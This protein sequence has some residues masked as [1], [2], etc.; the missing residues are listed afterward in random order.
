MQR[1]QHKGL[2]KLLQ[3]W[4]KG[5]A[6][7]KEENQLSKLAEEDAFLADALQGYQSVPESD[8]SAKIEKL[9]EKLSPDQKKVAIFSLPLMRVAASIAIIVFAIATLWYLNREPQNKLA[10]V[11]ME[12]QE[13]AEKG[14]GT[15]KESIAEKVEPQMT[16][17]QIAEEAKA[18]SP[19]AVTAP[20][21]KASRGKK[22]LE[23]GS[24][25]KREKDLNTEKSDV[26]ESPLRE[27]EPSPPVDEIALDES[28]FE[29]EKAEPAPAVEEEAEMMA[30]EDAVVTVPQEAQR[31]EETVADDMIPEKP[32][33]IIGRVLDSN[34]EPLIGAN[35]VVP[36]SAKG[37]LTDIDGN[38]R[39]EVPEGFNEIEVSYT[40]YGNLRQNL[41]AFDTM[42]F[43][44]DEALELSEVVV[45]AYQ[46]EKKKAAT[47][48]SNSQVAGK[49]KAIS[50]PKPKGGFKKFD[51][52]LRKNMQ[53][54]AA[55]KNASIE[56]KVIVDFLLDTEGKPTVFTIVQA[57][58]YGCDEEAIRLL[59]EGPKWYARQGQKVNYTIYFK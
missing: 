48:K 44:L 5:E 32:R 49:A 35:I 52:Y 55:A 50:P 57:L 16:Q 18:E 6:T 53:Y 4:L 28:A 51:R 39:L 42:D 34:N 26:A 36:G 59:R 23:K 10:D 13:E 8:H 9:R 1:Q 17:T 20:G 30:F 56:G 45:T 40:G 41:G 24:P 31:K 47:S 33:L 43:V 15:E 2:L 58:G 46:E 27:T 3:K 38:Y 25:S 21:Q 22:A 7:W 11:S 54:P 37:T 29:N 12:T 19:P 14:S